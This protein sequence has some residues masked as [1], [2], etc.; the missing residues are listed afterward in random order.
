MSDCI[1]RCRDPQRAILAAIDAW[2]TSMYPDA[3]ASEPD[4]MDK[5]GWINYAI[6]NQSGG[7]TAF[8]G[9]RFRR[10]KP[11]A[12]TVVIAAKPERDPWEWVHRDMGKLRPI[13]FAFG[14]PRPFRKDV[15]DDEWKYVFDLLG[16]AH[17]FLA[18]QS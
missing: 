9:T 12:L 1:S 18:V 8:A 10:D 11:T 7:A 5:E 13:G 16:Q 4:S 15:S 6:P 14:L 17:D 2:V 3:V